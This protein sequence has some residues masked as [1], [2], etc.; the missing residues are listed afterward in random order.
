MLLARRG[1]RFRPRWT[2]PGVVAAASVMIVAF[3]VVDVAMAVSP[4]PAGAARPPGEEPALVALGRRLFFD[5]A[6]SE[7]AGTSC[8]SCHDPARGFSG[9]HGSTIGVARGSRPGHFARRNT[10][11]VLYLK[12]VPRFHT[13][14]E[15]DAPQPSPFGGFFWDG[16]ADSIAELVMQPLTNPDEMNNHDAR[17]IA[18]KLR[19]GYANE[20]RQA[21]GISLDDPDRA[22]GALGQ[23]LQA[24]LTSPAMAPFSS[25]YDAYVRGRAVLAPDEARGLAL[26]KDPDKGNCASCHL[27]TVTSPT[28]ERSMFTDYGYDAVAVPRN[29]R[30]PAT[31]HAVAFD[32]GLCERGRDRVTTGMV[33]AAAITTGTAATAPAATAVASDERWCSNFRT[34]SL[35]N[36]AVRE[37]FMHNGAFTSLRDVVAFYATRATDPMRWYK[38]KIKFD[39]VPPRFR[40]QVNINSIPYNRRAGDT[41]ALDDRDIDAIV[42]FLRT[43]TDEQFH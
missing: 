13:Y 2:T 35:R 38:S 22:A 18:A 43:L 31:L 8:A 32:L 23:A 6:L 10:P 5:P 17:A 26:F 12:Y 40:G 9:S 37:A 21:L 27:L 19:A 11:S 20:F 15:E 16:R 30:L 28:P 24:F 39:D 4:S 41:P 33:A 29:R 1:L 7:P 25:K 42:A 34:P 36:V 14:Q 3:A